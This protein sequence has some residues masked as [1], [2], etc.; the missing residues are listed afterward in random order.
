MSKPLPSCMATMSRIAARIADTAWQALLFLMLGMPVA[1]ASG[2]SISNLTITTFKQIA[3]AEAEISI[4]QG[5][6]IT[7]TATT[8]HS[9]GTV[10]YRSV[11]PAIATVDALTGEVTAVLDGETTIIATQAAQP[12]YRQATASYKLKVNGT[13]A[14]SAFTWS[15]QTVRLGNT[16]TLNAPT[17]S[18][19][20]LGAFSYVVNPDSAGRIIAT[21]DNQTRVLTPS[22]AGTTTIT[23]TQ[24]AAGN[25]NEARLTVRL[26]VDE[27]VVPNTPGDEAPPNLNTLALA[28]ISKVTTDQAFVPAWTGAVGDPASIQVSLNNLGSHAV[29]ALAGDGRTIVLTGLAGE[30]EVVLTQAAQDGYQG[31]RVVASL[32]VKPAPFEITDF[33]DFEV[34]Y[35]L[36]RGY[37]PTKYSLP[38][39]LTKP[40]GSTS[41]FIFTI[42]GYSSVASIEGNIL[43]VHRRGQAT[44]TATLP[45]DELR[46]L[47]AKKQVTVY[48]EPY[49]PPQTGPVLGTG[50]VEVDLTPIRRRVIPV[51]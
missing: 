31:A 23:V 38:T 39:D 8:R 19:N 40:A 51:P 3:F 9:N 4:G 33:T 6:R 18:P 46:H 34:D 14:T 27:A 5:D 21:I 35:I 12:P 50:G 45:A 28:P 29:A 7:R 47:E 15:D 25:H 22:R 48:V 44:I 13:P 26:T 42:D 20:K 37:L 24:V 11:N 43:L 32:T 49:Y 30:A 16:L 1:W 2:V 10:S 36:G 17:D 41:D